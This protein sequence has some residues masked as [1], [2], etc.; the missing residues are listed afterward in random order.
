[1]S[2]KKDPFANPVATSDGAAGD[3]DDFDSAIDALDD[4]MEDATTDATSFVNMAAL[5]QAQHDPRLDEDMRRAKE[6]GVSMASAMIEPLPESPRAVLEFSDGRAVLPVTKS[7]M[8]I[9][10]SKD[11]AD[12][13]VAEDGVSRHHAALIFAS[14]EFFIEDLNSTNGTRLAGTRV[15]RSRLEPETLVSIGSV[16][17]KLRWEF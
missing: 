6:L 12:I 17:F 10:R 5:E 1:M 4:K 11:F 9:G 3:S 13:V 15:R 8:V 7:V 2:T 16:S 14:G